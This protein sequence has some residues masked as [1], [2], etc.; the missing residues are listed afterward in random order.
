MTTNDIMISILPYFVVIFFIILCIF[1]NWKCIDIQQSWAWKEK[2]AWVD[3]HSKR[4]YVI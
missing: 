2:M 3:S 1:Y 4:F